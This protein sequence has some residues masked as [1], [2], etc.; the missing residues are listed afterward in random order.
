M[1]WQVRVDILPRLKAGD[2]HFNEASQCALTCTQDLQLLDGLTPCYSGQRISPMENLW[3]IN[4]ITRSAS[5]LAYARIADHLEA[6]MG[7]QFTAEH[8]RQKFRRR[9]THGK[10]PSAKNWQRLAPSYATGAVECFPIQRSSGARSVVNITSLI[11]I[12]LYQA[13]WQGK[14]LSGSARRVLPTR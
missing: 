2:S 11:G 8:V 5:L 10:R 4:R 12:K 3:P 9:L 1:H 7:L 13:D 14:Q 6:R